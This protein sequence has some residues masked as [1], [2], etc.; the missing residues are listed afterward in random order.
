MSDSGKRDQDKLETMAEYPGRRHWLSLGNDFGALD[1]LQP[2]PIPATADFAGKTIVIC[3]DGTSNDPDEMDEGEASPTNVF[4]LYKALTHANRD[5]GRQLTWYDA[6]VGTGTSTAAKIGA[7]ASDAFNLARKFVPGWLGDL[8]PETIGNSVSRVLKALEAATGIWIE[9]NVEQGYAEIV[10]Q[11]E[12]GDRIFIFGFSRGAFT[13]RCIA[14]VIDRCGLLTTANIRHVPDVMKLYRRRKADDPTVPRQP[15]LRPDLIHPPADIRVHVLGLWDTVASLGLPL[16]GWWFRIGAFWR[17]K[18]LDSNPASICEH[19]YHV[20]AMDERRSQ[21]FPTMTTPRRDPATGQLIEQQSV[22]QVWLRGAHA[23]IGGAYANRTLGDIGLEWMLQIAQHHGLRLRHDIEDIP[24]HTGTGQPICRRGDPMGRLHS[25]MD[26]QAAWVIFGAWPRWAPVPRPAWSDTFQ[27]R[28]QEVFGAPHDLVYRRAALAAMAWR[29]RPAAAQV[30]VPLVDRLL[31]QDGLIY[32]GIG[33]KV[34]IEIAA[35]IVWN[36]TGV[37]FETA[38]SY[39]ITSVA[40]AWRDAERPPCG[41]DGQGAVGVDPVRW[42]FGRKRRLREAQWFELIGHVAHPRPWPVEEFGFKKL[43]KLLFLRDPKPLTMS[44]LR[45]G[46]YLRRPGESVEVVNLAS[47]GIFYAFANDGW[48]HYA[49][50]SGAIVIEIERTADVPATGQVFVVTPRGEV[51][52]RATGAAG[53]QDACDQVVKRNAILLTCLKQRITTSWPLPSF[54]NH[55]HG[56]VPQAPAEADLT[57]NPYPADAVVFT[58]P[59]AHSPAAAAAARLMLPDAVMQHDNAMIAWWSSQKT[60]A[61]QLAAGARWEVRAA[62]RRA[63]MEHLGIQLRGQMQAAPLPL[64][65]LARMV[66]LAAGI[67]V[68]A[69]NL[70]DRVNPARYLPRATHTPWGKTWHKDEV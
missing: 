58:D 17:S 7:W 42:F 64:D 1:N 27:A 9:E 6:G 53:A 34:R 61:A 68:Q 40:G 65:F 21:F 55:A 60:T 16:W 18:T 44:L 2:I 32:L 62:R 31:A 69:A 47:G 8:V 37:V 29:R 50:N 3:C 43:L 35:P 22:R 19:V 10:R 11:Y 38:A 30:P 54:A 49:N 48:A 70:V 51:L 5:A 23:D 45:L 63:G 67:Y 12:P 41:A 33:D 59:H 20:L 36:R 52:D 39:R 66:E 26:R 15:L 4:R 57:L 46:K 56:G 14:G 25:E 13:A 28:V 24:F